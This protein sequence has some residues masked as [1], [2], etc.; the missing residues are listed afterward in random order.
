[1]AKEERMLTPEEMYQAAYDRIISI[2]EAVIK[3]F[4]RTVCKIGKK[5]MWEWDCL[6]TYTYM[7]TDGFYHLFERN[8]GK[9]ARATKYSDSPK[10]VI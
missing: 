8:D 5:Y 2:G 7:G 6:S 9:M 10:E 4:P 3:A 1:M